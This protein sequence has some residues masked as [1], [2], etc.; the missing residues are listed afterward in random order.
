[1][2]DTSR[3]VLNAFSTGSRSFTDQGLKRS[4]KVLRLSNPAWS[5]IAGCD[6]QGAVGQCGVEKRGMYD[7][8][9]SA[10]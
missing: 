5:A 8:A 1:M 4:G 6:S 10:K 9:S 7:A 3:S 2:A